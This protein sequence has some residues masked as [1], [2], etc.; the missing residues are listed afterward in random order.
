MYLYLTIG[1]VLTFKSLH[2]LQFYMYRQME[3]PQYVV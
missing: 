3:S 2:W 1:E